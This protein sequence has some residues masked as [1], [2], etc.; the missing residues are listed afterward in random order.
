LGDTVLT[1]PYLSALRRALPGGATLDF[2]TR[3]EVAAIP[4][5]VELFDRVFEIGGGRNPRRQTLSAARLVL[6]LRLRR[7]QLVLD[8]QRNRISRMVR[9]A[10]SPRAWSEFDRFSPRL[11]GERTR[12]TIEA[13]G[14]G[15]LD[16]RPDLVLRRPEAGLGKLR[17][18][19][20]NGTSELVILNPGGAF[21]GRRW[22][23]ESY[24]RFAEL[25]NAERH[26]P[27]QFLTLGLP[28]IAAEARRMKDRLGD[29]LVDLVG[30]TTPDEAFALLH[31]T[32]LVLSEDSGLMHMAWVAGAPTLALFGASRGV[33]AR[34]HG[35][36]SAY[37]GACERPGGAC[38]DGRC[39]SGP[40]TCLARLAP[41]AVVDR[42]QALVE[43][44]AGVSKR[45]YADGRVYAPKLEGG[46]S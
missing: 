6:R 14:V 39:R 19:G 12:S 45:I 29:R 44:T 3:E 38:M 40:P 23:V 46:H 20:W 25:W 37:Q 33:W 36:Y 34:P 42:A 28:S 10:L 13:A 15:P 16:V 26:Q 30:R 27:A 1:L 11:A 24:V 8:L 31:R 4:K 21:E 35:N 5:G 7:Y 2:L 17:V 9:R 43:A 22:P 32:V 18:A 41:E